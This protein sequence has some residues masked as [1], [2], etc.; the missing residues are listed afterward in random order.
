MGDPLHSLAAGIR[1]MLIGMPFSVEV[2]G[3]IRW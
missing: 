1:D 2:M 3:K